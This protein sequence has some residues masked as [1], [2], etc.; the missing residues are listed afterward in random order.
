MS[1]IFSFYS[2]PGNWCTPQTNTQTKNAQTMPK[3]TNVPPDTTTQAR[4]NLPWW[5]SVHLH[6]QNRAA[7]SCFN[8]A[9]SFDILSY[10]LRKQK[11]SEPE[12]SA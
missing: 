9:T 8:A 7:Y 1:K 10:V 3:S 11:R 2:I 6:I 5:R 12:F 4:K